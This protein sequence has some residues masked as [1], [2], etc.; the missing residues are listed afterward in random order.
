MD[1]MLAMW[2]TQ[3]IRIGY[4]LPAEPTSS[5]L[6]ESVNVPD[7]AIEAIYTNLAVR[8]CPSL[9]K[10]PSNEL[11]ASA[12]QAYKTLL[13]ANV[14]RDEMQFPETLPSGAGNKPWRYQGE[15]MD[16]PEDHLTAQGLQS[17]DILEP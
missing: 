8:L 7:T 9:G 12:N 10:I 11:K 6:T 15:F 13:L 5:L 14:R 16:D 4:P 17:N 3:N 1:A 2:N